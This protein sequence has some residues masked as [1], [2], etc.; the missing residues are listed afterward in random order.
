VLHAPAQKHLCGRPARLPGD[1]GHGGVGD[2]PAGA[3]RAV[4]LDG[5][6][7]PTARVEEPAPVVLRVELDLVNRRGNRP[8]GDHGFE[9]GGAEI[10]DADRTGQ[11]SL[12][13]AFQASPGPGRAA[14]GP[15]HQVKVDLLHAKAPKAF[16]RLGDRVVPPRPRKIFRCEEHLVARHAAVAEGAADAFLIAVG[17]SRVNVPVSG[18]ERPARGVDA[19]APVWRLPDAKTEHGHLVPVCQQAHA[20]GCGCVH[21]HQH[22]AAYQA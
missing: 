18:L 11:P 15:V 3:E 16:L 19:L 7:V 5:D 2:V 4:G 1:L 17:L 12:A 9:V 13:G 8:V 10:G 6:V 21:A 14:F 20:A 22:L